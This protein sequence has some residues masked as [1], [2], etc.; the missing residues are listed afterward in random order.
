LGISRRGSSDEG[1]PGATKR[2]RFSEE[3]I[4]GILKEDERGI[5]MLKD[6]RAKDAAEGALPI[7]KNKSPA[8]SFAER[9]LNLRLGIAKNASAGR[10]SAKNFNAG[11]MM[12]GENEKLIYTVADV[13]ALTCF[14]RRSVIRWFPRQPGTLI[15]EWPEILHKRRYTSGFRGLSFSRSCSMAQ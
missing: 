10:S 6:T 3:Q 15:I 4:V 1:G 7:G 5:G 14:S 2:A 12:E 8:A 9:R 11:D 13:A